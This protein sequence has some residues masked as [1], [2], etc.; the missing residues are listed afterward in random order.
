MT[1]FHSD[2]PPNSHLSRQ[3]SRT[4]VVPK[5]HQRT[6][7]KPW[8]SKLPPSPIKVGWHGSKDSLRPPA[9]VTLA[10]DRGH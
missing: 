1:T 7:S 2:S 5:H 4:A 9:H 10:L 3:T 8:I 6:H